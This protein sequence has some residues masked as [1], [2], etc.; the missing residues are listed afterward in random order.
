VPMSKGVIMV[1]VLVLA[2][3]LFTKITV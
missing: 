3:V 1:K 2:I